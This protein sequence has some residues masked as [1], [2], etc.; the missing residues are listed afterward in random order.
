M[1]HQIF[2]SSH[3]LTTG[4]GLGGTRCGGP[5]SNVKHSGRVDNMERYEDR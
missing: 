4:G 2:S 5:E 3:L 1:L